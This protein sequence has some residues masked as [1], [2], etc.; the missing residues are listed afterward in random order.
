MLLVERKATIPSEN[1]K[2]QMN[3]LISNYKNNIEHG[4]R[5]GNCTREQ[6]ISRYN[7][8]L[9]KS[10]G[11][12]YLGSV[13]TR[14]LE[15][16]KNVEFHIYIASDEVLQGDNGRYYDSEKEL[17]L[18]SNLLF[19][20]NIRLLINKM[21]H[22]LIHGIQKHKEHSEEYIKIIDNVSKIDDDKRIP[23][24]TFFLYS[25]AEIQ[26]FDT[27]IGELVSNIL[28]S[29]KIS[30]RWNP[31]R[32]ERYYEKRMNILWNL[33][34]FL[35]SNKRKINGLNW[36]VG[37]SLIP[38]RQST[39]KEL[40][41]EFGDYILNIINYPIL[42]VENP[43]ISSKTKRERSMKN[44]KYKMIS[45]RRYNMFKQKLYNVYE[46]LLDSFKETYITKNQTENSK[47]AAIKFIQNLQN[48]PK[49]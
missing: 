19:N 38:N 36:E 5:M 30:D 43:R 22:E 9:A 40:F 4:C 15:T 13:R 28:D 10:G 26:E 41:Y 29:Y 18:N 31:K 6:M 45:N 3:Q 21:V 16:N 20:E 7:N 32:N 24:D 23:K 44:Q 46:R 17:Q 25:A 42:D 47:N 8:K 49:N 1:V 27:R 11:K 39:F 48:M 2:R 37:F 35:K 14:D 12:L 33:N 34:M